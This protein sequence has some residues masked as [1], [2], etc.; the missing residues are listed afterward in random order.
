MMMMMM[1][2]MIIEACSVFKITLLL[3]FYFQYD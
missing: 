1:M 2:M 3:L